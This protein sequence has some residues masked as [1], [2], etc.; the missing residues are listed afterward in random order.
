MALL[1]VRDVVKDYVRGSARVRALDRVSL[2]IDTG[3]LV[4]IMGPSGS[5]K[6]TLLH[7]LGGLDSP[8]SG[9]VIADGHD[10]AALGDEDLTAFRRHRLGFVFQ[11]FNLLPSLT[12]W[13]NVALPRLL[14]GK[15]L[16]RQRTRAVELL[17]RVGLGD[18]V[19]HKPA[20]MSGGQLQRVAIARALINDPVLVLADEPTGNLDSHTG[21]EVLALLRGLATDE[22]RTMVMVTHDPRAAAVGDRVIHLADGRVAQ[23]SAITV[24]ARSDGVS[25]QP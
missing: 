10:L 17:E 20:E 7:L 13:E 11:F 9:S 4:S 21:E 8:T 16:G 23:S 22:G 24:D 15:P 18:R 19:E 3:Q 1:E 14:D 5:G 12:A 6:S 25:V 2:T